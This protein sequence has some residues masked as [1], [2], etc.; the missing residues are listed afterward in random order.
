MLYQLRKCKLKNEKFTDV[1]M[2]GGFNIFSADITTPFTL[3]LCRVTKLKVLF[4]F[5]VSVAAI[6]G[7]GSIIF[8]EKITVEF[9]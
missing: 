9:L 4:L 1:C 3:E 6:F 8:G 5:L 7:E 2:T